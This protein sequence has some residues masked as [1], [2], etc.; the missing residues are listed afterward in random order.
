[1]KKILNE[2]KGY[3]SGS[4]CQKVTV[5]VPQRWFLCFRNLSCVDRITNSVYK[6]SFHSIPVYIVDFD[7][8]K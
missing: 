7:R 1:M 6:H 8:K 4:T 5:P 3:D 2:G